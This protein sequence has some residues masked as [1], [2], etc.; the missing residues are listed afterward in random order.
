MTALLPTVD[1]RAKR[2][3]ALAFLLRLDTLRR[4]MRL[5]AL[6]AIDIFSVWVALFVALA[7]KAAW[8]GSFD[9]SAHAHQA[10][11]LAPFAILVVLFNFA[12]LGLYGRRSERPGLGKIL[13]GTFQAMVVCMLFA[14]ID[15]QQFSSYYIF[16][17]GLVAAIVCIGLLR[18]MYES[19]SGWL[20]RRTGQQRRAVL[21]GPAHH[22]DAVAAALAED[23]DSA[24]RV[25][26]VLTVD[27]HGA[28]PK[29]AR[30]LGQVS[31]LPALL[32]QGVVDEVI[33]T[34]P[35]FPQ[36]LALE[37]VDQA[38]R[39][40]VHVRVAPSTMEIL[41]KRAEFLPGQTLPLF[42]LKPPVSEGVDF[43]I[44]RV[45]DLLVSTLI[46][47]VLSPVL[48]AIALGIRL[49]SAGPVIY[50]SRRPGVG[51]KPFDCFKF[52]TMYQ[53]AEHRQAELEEL[54]EAGGAIFKIRDD[55]RVTPV[56]KLL[57]RLSL[58]ELPQ[59][60]NVLR[61]EMSLV[62]PRPL[63]QR[64]YDRL[65]E[66]HKKRY[67][68]LPGV[69]GLWQVSGRSDLDF[70]D[71]VRLDF[72]YL[73]RWSVSLDLSILVKTIPAVFGRRGAF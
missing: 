69:T 4:A 62:G 47:L 40:G 51:G 58:D 57:R 7:L 24:I 64:D 37:V 3:T 30:S 59:L 61:G 8:L 13:T 71:M 17:G 32:S 39:R 19:A 9:A 67:H 28:R 31:D 27:E 60:L 15:G 50:R 68:V 11:E 41:V 54:N 21:I 18:L 48:L 66:W 38:H 44:K 23:V 70:D 26:G 35:A 25:S 34:D 42:E 52:R 33:I 46:L 45:F 20:L 16:W 2:P 73:E 22:S 53:D 5:V 56:G 29:R 14:L 1:V 43:A 49:T 63:P 36:D 10:R 65:E 12:R 6:L 72:L 55:P